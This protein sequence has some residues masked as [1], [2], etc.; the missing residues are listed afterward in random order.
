M[1]RIP[2]AKNLAQELGA[3]KK[4]INIIRIAIHQAHCGCVLP[5]IFRHI[6]SCK[7]NRESD[8]TQMTFTDK[9]VSKHSYYKQPAGPKPLASLTLGT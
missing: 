2:P 3:D 1:S 9:G 6:L 5:R 8:M 7:K 4:L